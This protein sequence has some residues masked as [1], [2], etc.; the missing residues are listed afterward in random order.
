M[1]FIDNRKWLNTHF[2]P[3]AEMVREWAD[4]EPT[5]DVIVEPA[6]T[7][8]LTLK[9]NDQGKMKYVH[10]KY[11]PLKEVDRILKQV[12]ED[13]NSVLFFGVG[14]GYHIEDFIKNNP[15]TRIIL[16]EP[17]EE[18]FI[19]FLKRVQLKQWKK[20]SVLAIGIGEDINS[21][22]HMLH[23][24]LPSVNYQIQ[25]VTIPL[26]ES[27]YAS[28]YQSLTKFIVDT[29]KS[30]KSSLVTDLSFQTRWITNAIK[31][32]PTVLRTPNMLSDVDLNAFKDK[33]AIIV[34]AGPS[35]NREIENLR[36]IK[37]EGRAYLF[38]VGS[39]IN[40]LIAN[41]VVPDAVCT[42]DPQGHNERVIKVVREQNIS[43]VP[44]IFGSSVG[45]E[46]LIDYPNDMY[47]MVTSQDTIIPYLT[48]QSIHTV[49]DAPS[50]AVV[51]YQLL[52]DLGC[53]PIV[54][55][56][57]NLAYV[58]DEHYAKGIDYGNGTKARAEVLNTA[59]NIKNVHGELVKTNEGFNQMRQQLEFYIT[60]G[61][62]K[63][64]N[65]TVGGAEIKGATFEY[66]E[67]LLEK[68]LSQ[69]GVV[70]D[71]SVKNNNYN[72]AQI[73]KQLKHLTEQVSL[74]KKNIV[75]A[76]QVLKQVNDDYYLR[77]YHIIE[78]SYGR[79][80]EAISDIQ[81]ND[82]YIHF[83][84]RMIRVQFEQLRQL[85]ENVRYE[86]NQQKKGAIIIPAFN[87]YLVTI[88]EYSHYAEELFIE[89][90]MKIEES[91]RI[92]D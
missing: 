53:S 43:G 4:R 33:P 6:K 51:T 32:A 63:T 73:K 89:M 81:S 65:T 16:Y 42:Y 15:S 67:N 34:A 9:V 11:D 35:L 62:R 87:K 28:Q 82:F 56:G 8:V 59:I 70:S 40:T 72:Q 26:Y 19:S 48:N 47:H 17:D 24:V 5:G 2:R 22:V 1:N 77:K 29:L 37:E 45:F 25:V 7:G 23:R 50:I 55:V 68:D 52:F 41:D 58:D 69:V 13:L 30:N 90:K 86:T 91:G 60:S 83:V 80:D 3:V 78:N 39:A 85:I 10:S 18:V 31:N 20:D 54:L 38:S 12:S 66:L 46:T 21:V 27:L 88:Q 92:N 44:L 36:K 64:Y 75:E 14:L 49:Q 71:W 57:Q 74:N 84:E 79:L 61:K 76:F